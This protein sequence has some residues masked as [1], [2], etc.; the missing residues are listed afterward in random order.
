VSNR[1]EFITLLGGAAVAWPLAARAQQPPMLVIGFLRSTSIERSA[2]LVAAFLRGLKEAG[3]VE[4]QNVSIVYRSAEGQYDRLPALAAELVQH[5][6]DIIVATGGSEP[7][8]AAKAATTTI[9]I[10]F[11]GGGDPVREG[12][13]SS[14]NRPA[15]NLTGVSLLTIDIGS[16]RLGLLRELVPNA[17]TIAMLV[18][19]NSPE[20]GPHLRDVQG[21]A[22]SLGQ[23]IQVLNARNEEEIDSAFAAMARERPDALLMDPDPFLVSRREQIVT[24]ANHYRIPALYE[25]RELAEAG[26]L[27]SYGPSHTEPYRLIGIY[28]GRI[29]KG[30]KPAELP[31][32]QSTK[33]ELVINL[34]T[35]K[36]IGFEIPPTLLARADEVIE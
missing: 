20:L 2:H 13:V 29:L 11:S 14:L 25:W 34:R 12:F 31:V 26:G 21:A 8:R 22:H 19:P 17:K 24:L 32:I 5:R 1:R 10:V 36:R 9:P 4:G 15:G 16:K 6:V 7:A 30:A 27:A 23:Q 33:F 35:A 28:T 18:N 3:Y